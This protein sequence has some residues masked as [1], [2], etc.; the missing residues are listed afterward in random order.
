M[1]TSRPSASTSNT[2]F[3]V[4]QE[5]SSSDDP[6][7]QS[8][9]PSGQDIQLRT[10]M[11]DALKNQTDYSSSGFIS[12]EEDSLQ[13]DHLPGQQKPT[14]LESAQKIRDVW[15]DNFFVELQRINQCISENYNY[16]AMVS[17]IRLYSNREKKEPI[18]QIVRNNAEKLGLILTKSTKAINSK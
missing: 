8:V 14:Y 17:M 4:S 10:Q 2:T 18:I 7:N 12:S 3:E 6:P 5:G 16:V 15:I 1:A 13:R 11:K 9:K